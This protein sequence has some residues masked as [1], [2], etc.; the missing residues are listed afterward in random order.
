M[1][2]YNESP[3][4]GEAWRRAFQLV[5]SNDYGSAPSIFY[6]EEDV[7][8]LEGDKII[9]NHVGQIGTVF[10]LDNA[11]T[12]FQLRNPDT[13]E[14]IEAYATFQDLFVMLH[15]LYF[16]LAKERDLPERGPQPYPS[17][18][19]SEETAFW[20]APIPQ[21]ESGDWVWNEALQE[22]MDTSPQP[23]VE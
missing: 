9:K 1:P 14:Y 17:W 8:L 4:Q 19:W 15:S 16:H 3:V 10:T 2:K 12:Q 23:S 22:W 21:P 11:Q 20:V 5:G 13:E 7:V 18:V 6:N